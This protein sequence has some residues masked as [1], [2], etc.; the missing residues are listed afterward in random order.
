MARELRQTREEGIKQLV[1]SRFVFCSSTI[2]LQ[3]FILS[4]A[5]VL[6]CL[7]G[8]MEREWKKEIAEWNIR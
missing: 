2:Q 8:V 6:I 4:R 5:E 3:L 1:L 7:S